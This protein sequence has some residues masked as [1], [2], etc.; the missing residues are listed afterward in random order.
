M[1]ELEKEWAIKREIEAQEKLREKYKQEKEERKRYME[2]F[3]YRVSRI[4][5]DRRDK[6]EGKE[7]YDQNMRGLNKEE[8]MEIREEMEDMMHR[9]GYPVDIEIIKD[10]MHGGNEDKMIE[11]MEMMT[12]RG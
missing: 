10:L 12:Q 3:Y 4:K 9:G 8:E 11:L 1:I 7:T 5:K 6:Q 2:M